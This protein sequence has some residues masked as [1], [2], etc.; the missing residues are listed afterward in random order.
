[1]AGRQRANC[2]NMGRGARD[3]SGRGYGRLPDGGGIALVAGSGDFQAVFKASVP[4]R[5]LPFIVI[6]KGIFF[7]LL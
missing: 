6:V 3:T 5:T 4:P 7:S 1:M 2:V